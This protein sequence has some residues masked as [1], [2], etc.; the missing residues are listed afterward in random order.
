MAGLDRPIRDQRKKL[1]DVAGISERAHL[2]R[3]PVTWWYERPDGDQMLPCS[4]P[5]V[6]PDFCVDFSFEI[7]GKVHNV[8]SYKTL[9]HC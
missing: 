8:I 4:N 6:N 9:R 2:Y 7:V 5:S 3:D 1:L